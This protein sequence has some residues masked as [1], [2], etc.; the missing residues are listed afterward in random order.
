[1]SA[2]SEPEKKAD[3][4][5]KVMSVPISTL[6]DSSSKKD[7]VVVEPNLDDKGDAEKIHPWTFSA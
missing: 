4:R 6:R 5:I 1:M 7:V 3:R 2:V